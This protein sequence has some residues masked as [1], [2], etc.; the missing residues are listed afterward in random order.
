[1]SE[2]SR[3]YDYEMVERRSP[4]QKRRKSTSPPTCIPIT[5]PT[6]AAWTRARSQRGLDRAGVHAAGTNT[7]I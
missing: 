2:R 4:L 5:A 7:L 6:W 3:P 1:M